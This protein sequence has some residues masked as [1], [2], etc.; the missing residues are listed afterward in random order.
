MLK[1][2]ARTTF[3]AYYGTWAFDFWGRRNC[4][5]YRNIAELKELIAPIICRMSKAELAL[6]P[7][8]R[9]KIDLPLGH[10]E[11]YDYLL[12][13]YNKPIK[14]IKR[15]GFN[16]KPGIR[17]EM[18]FISSTAPQK[19]EFIKNIQEKAASILTIYKSAR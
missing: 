6:P 8:T 5:G 16:S 4:T 1:E 12:S 7:K 14:T 11:R 9:R 3:E 13:L 10:H 18:L 15:N 19:I 17:A 2:T